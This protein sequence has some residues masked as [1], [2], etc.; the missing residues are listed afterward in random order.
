MQSG[1]VSDLAVGRD[2]SL[3]NAADGSINPRV[4]VLDLSSLYNTVFAP[5]ASTPCAR[6]SRGALAGEALPVPS[7]YAGSRAGAGFTMSIPSVRGNSVAISSG[8]QRP[9]FCI[10]RTGA[11]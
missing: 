7:C 5:L 6:G 1:N 4:A 2:A 10:V 3:G 9:S 8:V 11:G